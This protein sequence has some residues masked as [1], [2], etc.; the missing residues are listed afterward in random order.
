[1]RLEFREPVRC[2]DA[3]FGE[4]ADIIIDPG[5]GR[6]THVVVEPHHRHY[7]AR[8]VALDRVQSA[9]AGG[10]TLA[11]SVDEVRELEAVQ[12]V[13]MLAPGEAMQE[14]PDSDVGIEHVMVPSV[15]E[16]GGIDSMGIGVPAIAY[17]PNVTL[18]Y[19]RIPKGCVELRRDSDVHSSDGE[20]LGHVAGVETD[21]DDKI[22][23]L[24][25]EHRHLFSKRDIA[26]PLSAIARLQTDAVF[27]QLSAEQ[28]RELKPLSRP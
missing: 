27:L 12:Q 26:I 17:D 23:H 14:D 25:L 4:L 11:C 2:T 8:L 24:V 18:T 15:Y 7:E 28:A 5:S 21:S 16:G 3:E 10:I 6:V 19:D 9:D 13:E 20:R 1:M 22:A